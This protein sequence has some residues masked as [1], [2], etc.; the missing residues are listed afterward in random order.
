MYLISCTLVFLAAY[1]LNITTITVGYHRGLAHGALQLHP[2]LRQVFIVAGNWL[3]GLDP[4]AWVVMH[5]RHHAFSDTPDDPHSPRNVGLLGIAMEQLRSYQR[6][7]RGLKR[8]DPKYVQYAHDLDFELSWL[9]R[10]GRW[11]LPYVLHAAVGLSL[12]FGA[13]LWLLA[14]AYFF[15]MMSHPVQGGLVNAFGHAV[16]GRNFETPDD[17]RNNHP[18]AWLVMGEGF[19][20]N[21]HRYPASAKF[22]YTA[23][24]VDPGFGIAKLMQAMGL[25]RISSATMIPAPG[26]AQELASG[27]E[28]TG[29]PTPLPH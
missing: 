14:A 2:R 29:D 27:V 12:G 11:Y 8:K 9:N 1:M 13:H 10:S 22:S 18:V 5:R 3:T 28:A 7:I 6:V 16:G 26:A 20:N 15:G 21:H 23:W 24:E 19:Q 25:L 4:K 17:S